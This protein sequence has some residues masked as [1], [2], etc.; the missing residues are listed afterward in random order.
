MALKSPI[1]TAVVSKKQGYFHPLFASTSVI[2]MCTG[3][4][5]A[6]LILSRS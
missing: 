5:K 2:L 6:D 1:K 4:P 3:T